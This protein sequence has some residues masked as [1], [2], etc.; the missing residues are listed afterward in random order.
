MWTQQWGGLR[1]RFSFCTGSV[2]PRSVAD[3]PLDLQVIPRSR[4]KEVSRGNDHI[5]IDPFRSPENASLESADRAATEQLRGAWLPPTLHDLDRS[6]ATSPFRKQ[7]RHYA[8]DVAPH[9]ASFAPVVSL[10]TTGFNL[11]PDALAQAAGFLARAYPEPSVGSRLKTALLGRVARDEG[12]PDASTVQLEVEID[13]LEVF[14]TLPSWEAFDAEALQVEKRVETAIEA[15]ETRRELASRLLGHE[16]NSWGER[17]FGALIGEMS[18]T[19]IGDVFAWDEDLLANV[20]RRN[21][22]L[23]EERA[24]WEAPSSVQRFV[25]R[26]VAATVAPE[27]DVWLALVGGV[28]D[29]GSDLAAAPVRE[30]LGRRAAQYALDWLST[31]KR[32]RLP[33]DWTRVVLDEPDLLYEWIE[34]RKG[35]PILPTCALVGQLSPTDRHV[36][37]WDPAPLV[38]VAQRARDGITKLSGAT[39]SERFE[40]YA[41]ALTV[42]L[43]IGLRSPSGEPLVRAAFAPVHALTRK[44]CLGW[45]RW[46]LLSSLGRA[47]DWAV[48]DRPSN[49][50]QLERAA[51]TAYL[52]RGWPPSQFAK[53]VSDDSSLRR[54]L[55]YASQSSKAGRRFAKEVWHSMH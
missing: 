19:E 28:L 37:T 25:L 17:A 4:R 26:T 31:S 16:R 54:A 36:L 50:E 14:L 45:K 12:S 52:R 7:L 18:A 15:K 38:V 11:G 29:A 6:D 1:S 51:V 46:R 8:A 49:A 9:R 22:R 23:V 39:G 20:L 43:A 48:W 5:A 42:L 53:T 47:P 30:V 24:V 40:I 27:D 41:T 32:H 2:S 34:I 21:P 35:V 33:P 44:N 3:R 13:R 55:D 10:L